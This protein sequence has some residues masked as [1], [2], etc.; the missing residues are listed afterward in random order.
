MKYHQSLDDPN[1]KYFYLYLCVE[2]V[3]LLLCMY[4]FVMQ[5][6]VECICVYISSSSISIIIY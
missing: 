3:P 5:D 6:Y 2:K 4:V 1:V